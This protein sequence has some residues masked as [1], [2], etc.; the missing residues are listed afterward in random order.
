MCIIFPSLK[1]KVFKVHEFGLISDET[2]QVEPGG[3]DASFY[4]YIMKH[5]FAMP[6]ANRQYRVKKPIDRFE[7][8]MLSY[9]FFFFF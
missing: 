6:Y 4:Y 3:G 5:I 8:V 2:A 1:L 7:I 9:T